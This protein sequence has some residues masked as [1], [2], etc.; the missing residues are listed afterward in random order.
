MK[1]K[2]SSTHFDF[3]R[4]YEAIAVSHFS[5]LD[6]LDERRSNKSL[7]VS[8]ACKSA[9]AVYS[10]KASSLL[11][12]RP[13]APAE[14]AN[15]RR[16]FGIDKIPSDSGLK[17]ILDRVDSTSLRGVFDRVYD[18]LRQYDV[19]DAYRFHGDYLTVSIDGVHHYSSQKVS[20]PCCLEKHHRDGS[21]TYSHSLLSAALVH[22]QRAEVFVLDNEPIVKQDGEH[23]NDCERSAAGRLFT[24]LADRL[25]SESVVYALDA[26]YGCAPVIKLITQ[27]S[28]AWRYVINA[29]EA[30]HKHLFAQFDQRNE[31]GGVKWRTLRRKDGTYAIG[32]VSDLELNASNRQVRT[33]MV[34]LNYQPKKGAP[35]ITFSWM[36]NLELRA[37][38]VMAV[39][40][41]GRSRWKIENEVFNTLKN[42]QYNF[43]HNFGHG[44]Q[45]LATNFAYLM[46][47]AFT[48][49]QLRQYGS[50]LFRSIWKGLKTKKAVWDA[51][52]TVFKMVSCQTI[53]DLCHKVLDIYQL[54]TIRV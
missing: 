35:P 22:A 16:C 54:R 12:F 47:L 23:K 3:D 36:T 28:A 50:R 13:K 46:M 18:Y 30:G 38:T 34:V 37:D 4:V 17:K 33:N 44:Q 21:I 32:Y 25:G 43:D 10:L 26:L 52:R 40:Q 39:T 7:T 53:D 27:T 45:H 41:I 14:E 24:T 15:L 1:G 6:E 42:Q 20:C 5:H 29:R 31:E 9:F 2:A 48:I 51:I 11:D 8:D 19:I 49:D